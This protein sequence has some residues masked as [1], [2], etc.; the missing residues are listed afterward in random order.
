[1]RE[2]S[3]PIDVNQQKDNF[4]AVLGHEL[5]NPVAAI[6]MAAE[7]LRHLCARNENTVAM[8]DIILRQ[9]AHAARLLDDLLDV[10]R[11]ANGKI[12][13][14][15]QRLD[16][17][18]AVRTIVA[19]RHSAVDAARLELTME[20][21]AHPLWVNADPTRI[22]QVVGNLITNAVKFTDPPGRISV[23]VRGD[24]ARNEATI[25]I[26]DTGVGIEPAKLPQIFEPFQ[27][28]AHHSERNRE[29]LGLGLAV[30]KGL[31]AMHGGRIAAESDGAGRGTRFIVALPLLAD[32]SEC[33]DNSASPPTG[34]RRVLIIDDSP[35][36][37]QSLEFLFSMW[38]HELL[39][40]YHGQQGIDIAQREKP[41]I[42]LCDIGLPGM[43]GYEVARALRAAPETRRT[44][45]I[46]VSGFS[47][48]EDK[49]RARAAGFDLHLN[50]PEGFTTLDRLLRELPRGPVNRPARLPD[51]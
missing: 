19:D 22:A 36:V 1:M 11:I 32:A 29:G 16:L 24:V 45:L 12:E 6:T 10:S 34:S 27:Q 8:V 46:A 18:S 28:A 14:R 15:Q 7:S 31:V 21:P 20:F 43:S 39:V 5:R 50:K 51:R 4:L 38:G 42:I 3:D 41:E 17:V 35:D 2:V 26:A 49:E 47:T 23:V 30:A 9:S 13:L 25:E 44:Y 40:A 48:A 33:A 37:V